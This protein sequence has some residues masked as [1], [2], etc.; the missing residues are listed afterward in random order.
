MSVVEVVTV[1]GC[2]V[3]G[4]WIM[5]VFIPSLMDKDTYSEELQDSIRDNEARGEDA[6]SSADVVCDEPW[7]EV[8]GVAADASRV[9]IS[10]AYKRKIREY[11]PDRV[12]QMG[13]E[14]RDVA[15]RKSKQINM[16]YEQAMG[17]RGVVW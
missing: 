16:A 17:L 7:H 14:I 12:A 4:Y 1:I 6:R 10:A 15:E 3:L 9:E 11:H 2:L 5:A 13:H 8:L